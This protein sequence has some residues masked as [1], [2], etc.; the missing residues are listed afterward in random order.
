MPLASLIYVYICVWVSVCVC[1]CLH[2]C[3]F[4]FCFW[5]AEVTLNAEPLCACDFCRYKNCMLKK[6]H[7]TKIEA[8][9]LTQKNQ[10]ITRNHLPWQTFILWRQKHRKVGTNET[11]RWPL[12]SPLVVKILPL[13]QKEIAM[14]W[15][16]IKSSTWASAWRKIS[17]H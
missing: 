6:G 5:P 14:S 12:Y 11:G 8:F 1:T 13:K 4:F 7:G 2:V 15:C 16:S 17:F 10:K 3:C 9:I